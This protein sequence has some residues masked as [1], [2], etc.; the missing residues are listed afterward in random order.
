VSR[1]RGHEKGVRQCGR[2]AVEAAPFRVNGS[3]VGR[4]REGN[5][6]SLS[7]NEEKDCNQEEGVKNWGQRFRN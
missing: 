3:Q 4:D 1:E 5:R 6:G 2:R 7:S